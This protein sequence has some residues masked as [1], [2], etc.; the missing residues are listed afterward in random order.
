MSA[1][2][3]IETEVNQDTKKKASFTPTITFEAAPTVQPVKIEAKPVRVVSAEAPVAKVS[4][5]PVSTSNQSSSKPTGFVYDPNK[6]FKV[7]KPQTPRISFEPAPKI[8]P[9]PA[10]STGGGGE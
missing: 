10:S 6:N 2:E 3:A 1:P 9:P 7:K 5:E 8:A 4:H